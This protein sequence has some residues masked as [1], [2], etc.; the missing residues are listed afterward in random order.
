M[1]LNRTPP[2]GLELPSRDIVPDADLVAA[3]K[4][5]RYEV[6]MNAGQFW[7][8][9]PRLLVYQTIHDRSFERTVQQAAGC[10]LL[11][12]SFEDIVPCFATE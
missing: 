9:D 12:K 8:A 4:G 1:T 6:F 2:N 5:I 11:D 7:W 10:G 3:A